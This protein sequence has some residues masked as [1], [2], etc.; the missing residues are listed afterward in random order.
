MRDANGTGIARE[1]GETKAAMTA[2]IVRGIRIG[3]G[4]PEAAPGGM[5]GG[6]DVTVIFVQ[7]SGHGIA[8]GKA[9]TAFSEAIAHTTAITHCALMPFNRLVG[10]LAIAAGNDGAS[11][12]S[13]T[14]GGAQVEV[15]PVPLGDGCPFG[16]IGL[17]KDGGPHLR[18]ECGGKQ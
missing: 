6:G 17:G 7:G 5:V 12:C 2:R 11:Q 1:F 15:K 14:K 18:G 3:H 16:G 13:R 9:D 4:V 10:Q 8:N